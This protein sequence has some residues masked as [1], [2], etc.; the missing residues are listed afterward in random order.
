VSQ[1][2][3]SEGLSVKKVK[4]ICSICHQWSKSLQYIVTSGGLSLDSNAINLLLVLGFSKLEKV[5][6]LET[7]RV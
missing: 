5:N 7:Q 6:P 1:G 2:R 4:D 3:L